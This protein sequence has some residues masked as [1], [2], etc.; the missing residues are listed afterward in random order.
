MSHPQTSRLTREEEAFLRA[1]LWEEAHLMKGPAT[2]AAE[3]HGLSILRSLEPA[4][5]LSPNLHGE[6]LNRLADGPCPS[7]PWPWATRSGEEVLQLLWDRLAQNPTIV[8]ETVEQ[9]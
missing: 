5:R 2:Q 9:R 3:E 4:N 1:I 6:A 8:A 7:A